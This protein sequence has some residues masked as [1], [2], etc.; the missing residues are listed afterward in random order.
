TMLVGAGGLATLGVG[1]V[2]KLAAAAG[3]AHRNFRL[4]GIS[5]KTAKL[6]VGGVGAAVAIG[7]IALSAWADAQA[8]ARANA[9]DFASTLLVVDGQVITTAATMQTINDKLA[10]TQTL[11]GWGPSLL[12][13]MDQVGVSASDAQGYLNGEADAIARVDAALQSYIR[14]NPLMGSTPTSMLKSGLDDLRGS[15]TEAE[16]STLQKSRADEEAGVTAKS[17]ADALGQSTAA[18]ADNTE[19]TAANASEMD[20][21]I[22]LQWAAADAA[23]ALSGSQVGFERALDST[24]AATKKLVKETK[25]K[26][27]LTDIDTKA[28][29]DAKD[30]LDKIATATL[31]RTK[32]MQ[33]ARQPQE[34]ITAETE[35]GRKALVAQAR[36][37]GFSESA[38]ADLVSKY[39][40][41]PENVT[42]VV[43]EDGSSEAETRVNNLM[44]AIEDLP[45]ESQTDILSEFN[46]KGIEAAERALEK[47]DGKTATTTIVT[48]HVNKGLTG[49]AAD[50][51]LFGRGLAGIIRQ[52]AA[53][54][55]GQPQLR[56]FQG[57]QGV[58]WGE[59]GSGPWEAFISGAPQKR[60]RSIAIWRE[61]GRRL[62]GRF[63][64][65][66]GIAE[67]LHKGQPLSFWERELRTPLELTRLKIQIRDLEKDLKEKEKYGK[68][69]KK[70]TRY[71]LRGLDRTEAQQDLAETREEL[72]LALIADK[73]N[74]SKQGT[75]EQPIA[76][77]EAKSAA[78][79]ARA[80]AAAAKAKTAAADQADA[81]IRQSTQAAAEQARQQ[82]TSSPV[83]SSGG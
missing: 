38:I 83:T 8:Q 12:D 11:L 6:A 23:L 47:I 65:E 51:G 10:E 24:R 79:E 32:A 54:G 82:L 53:G 75:I 42:T 46:N 63:S 33:K 36:Q 34:E 71:V 60:D 80:E 22:R 17:Y 61:V 37:M 9:E 39:D 44:D 77:W 56:P 64:A 59:Q 48:R 21:W 30:I 5:A 26:T 2:L 25:D 1:G 68:G 16:R 19:A 57:S 43:N 29:Q 41:L 50:G 31:T 35:R 45:E 4:L 13:L 81:A 67:P 73:L 3:D 62:L 66:G 28:G 70:K 15:M 58:Q 27:D 69:K 18:T 72:R 14:S 20:E 7:A 49:E 78:A 40:L 52:F 74:R 76:A 55:F